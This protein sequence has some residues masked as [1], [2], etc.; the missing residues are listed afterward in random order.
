MTAYLS[1]PRYP[2]VHT[3][4]P[5]IPGLGCDICGEGASDCMCRTDT[6]CETCGTD[7]RCETCGYIDCEFE[8]HRPHCAT[9]CCDGDLIDCATRCPSPHLHVGAKPPVCDGC[10]CRTRYLDAFGCVS[11]ANA[12]AQVAIDKRTM[13]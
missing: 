10:E 2:D 11:A 7:A 8:T 12:R 1:D 13:P 5:A 4:L 3:T 9:R 6:P